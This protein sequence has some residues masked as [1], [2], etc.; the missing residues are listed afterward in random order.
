MLG[1]ASLLSR[2]ALLAV[3]PL[4]QRIDGDIGEAEGNCVMSSMIRRSVRTA[5]VVVL[6]L[7]SQ[8]LGWSVEEAP[9]EVAPASASDG[10]QIVAFSLSGYNS[11]GSKRWDLRGQAAEIIGEMVKLSQVVAVA[12]GKEVNVTLTGDEGTLDKSSNDMTLENHVVATTTD[13]ARLTTDRLDWHAQSQQVTTD[14]PV[15]VEK[16]NMEIEGTAAVAEPEQKRVTVQKDVTVRV[17]PATLITCAGPLEV[18]YA[19]NIAVFHENVIVTDDRGQI[20]ADR[21]DVWFEPKS[22]AIDKVVATGHVVI[23]RGE[24]RTYSEQAEY[25]AAQ[26]KVVLIGAP[27]LEIFSKDDLGF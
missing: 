16:Q 26:N 5:V 2:S 25:Y 10:Q 18:D 22:N 11:D 6:F 13:G 9:V 7:V 19:N 1:P 24:N 8:G 23:I 20:F 21:M 3:L 17:K 12:Y 4:S 15:L 14:A 27:R